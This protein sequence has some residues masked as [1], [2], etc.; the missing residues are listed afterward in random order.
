[1]LNVI[2]SVELRMGAWYPLGGMG[3]IAE[4]LA[5]TAASYGV[6]IQTN[7]EV[8]GLI[9]SNSTITKVQ[10]NNALV[11]TDGVI[12]NSDALWTYQRLLSPVGVPIPRSLQKAERSCSGFLLLAAVRASSLRLAHHNVFFSDDYQE[13]FADI[14]EHRQL[15]RGM[16]IYLSISSK[17]DPQLVPEGWENWYILINAPANGIDHNSP[18]VQAE[19]AESVWERLERGFG[20]K[21]EI[22]WQVIMPARSIEQRYHSLDGAIYGTSSN[23]LQSAFFRP[24]QR[25]RGLKNFYLAG[26]STHPGGGIPLAMLSGKMVAGFL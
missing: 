4:A 6:S 16:T 24:A 8:I 12:S 5:K 18:E 21:P 20:I 25:V 19:Y 22:A 1:M 9:R 3:K 2:A 15:P 10:T 23:S 14:F 7:T 17:S 26:G 13:E 11:E